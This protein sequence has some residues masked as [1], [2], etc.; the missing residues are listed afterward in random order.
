MANIFERTRRRVNDRALPWVLKNKFDPDSISLSASRHVSLF[1]K[2]NLA[3]NR[4]K[5]N[6]NSTT[7]SILHAMEHGSVADSNDA[8]RQAAHLR[9]AN[10][11]LFM[12]AGK[13]FYVVIIRNPYSRLLSAFLNKF[14]KSEFVD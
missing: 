10:P 14:A 12:S 9:R 11:L 5:K 3:F 2:L 6:G 4:V 8:K 13:L 7:M 1:P